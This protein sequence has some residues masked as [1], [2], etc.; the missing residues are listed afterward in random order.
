MSLNTADTV[1]LC[2]GLICFGG[3]FIW[4]GVALYLAYTRIPVYP[5]G[6]NAGVFEKL[7]RR[8]DSRTTAVRRALGET[9]ADWGDLRDSY[10]PK[11]LSQ[12]WRSLCRGL[13]GVSSPA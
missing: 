4:I 1:F 12:T 10:L 2:V 8:H 6:R 9:A 7:L 3:I 5:Y 11:R 13:E